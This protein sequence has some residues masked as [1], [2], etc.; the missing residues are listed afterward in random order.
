M[1]LNVNDGQRYSYVAYTMLMFGEVYSSLQLGLE[2]T[3]NQY[4]MVKYK[5]LEGVIQPKCS[6]SEYSH[7]GG[8]NLQL[9]YAYIS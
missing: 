8:L 6:R 7:V 9:P 3:C 5:I 1:Y 4:C 2:D